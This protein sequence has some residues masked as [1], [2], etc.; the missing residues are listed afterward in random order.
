MEEI[1]ASR[2]R[3]FADVSHELRAA[4]GDP[5]RVRPRHPF[6]RH[7]GRVPPGDRHHPQAGLRLH[8]RVGDMLRV[9]LQ[10]RPDRPRAAPKWVLAGILAEAVESC[11]PEAKATARPSG[12]GAERRRRRG[13]G[14]CRVAA[15]SR[16]G[17]IDNALRHAAGATRIGVGFSPRGHGAAVT[18][19][20]DGPGPARRRGLFERFRRGEG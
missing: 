3:F 16:R 6:A 11:A 9:A 13:A 18:V 2:R 5:R 12:A 4:H 17:L 20:D 15:P 1:D 10:V 14:R 7:A 19:T 8:R